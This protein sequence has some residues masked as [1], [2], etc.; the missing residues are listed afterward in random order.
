[1][2]RPDRDPDTGAGGAASSSGTTSLRL[3]KWLWFARFFKTRSIAAGEVSAGHVR[4]N[5]A[6]AAKPAEAVRAG[7]TLTFA[8]GR[9]IRVVRIVALPM[10]RGPAP[11]ARACYDDLSPPP[12]PSAAEQGAPQRVPGRVDRKERRAARLSRQGPLD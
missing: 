6:R 4:V 10:R 7:D 9:A 11:E 12:P 8:Q 5:G 2:T 1:M 3:D